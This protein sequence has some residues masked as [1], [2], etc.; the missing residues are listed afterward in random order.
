MIDS[1]VILLVPKDIICKNYLC[2][3]EHFL[4]KT[5]VK[6]IQKTREE[7]DANGKIIK[8]RADDILDELVLKNGNRIDAVNN[9]TE[10]NDYLNRY[11]TILPRFYS[12]RKLEDDEIDK[13]VYKTQ[14]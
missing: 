13:I 6:E 9:E 4:R 14:I 2:D 11:H 10:N 8:P 5:I 7:T 3:A 12:N 1:E